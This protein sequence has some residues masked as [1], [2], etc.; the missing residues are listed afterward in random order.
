MP[1]LMDA[2]QER[3]LQETEA[4][5]AAR[6]GLVEGRTLCAVAECGAAISPERTALGA[7]LCLECQRG[8]E[9]REAHFRTWCRR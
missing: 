3:V 7:Q 5:I 4:A 6:T 1:D 2:V 8:E 9:A